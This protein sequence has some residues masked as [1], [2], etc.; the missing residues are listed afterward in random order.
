[1]FWKVFIIYENADCN[2]TKLQF[3]VKLRK[4]DTDILDLQ[5]D[6]RFFMKTNVD[7]A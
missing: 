1:M 3:V 4:A 2:E 7:S 6:G 5:T